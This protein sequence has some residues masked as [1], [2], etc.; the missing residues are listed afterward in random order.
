MTLAVLVLAA[1]ATSPIF[2]A[3]LRSSLNKINGNS[4]QQQ[5]RDFTLLSRDIQER[6]PI[7]NFWELVTKNLRGPTRLPPVLQKAEGNPAQPKREVDDLV[8]RSLIGSLVVL[9]AGHALEKLF[10][11]EDNN[12]RDVIPDQLAA[13]LLLATRSIEEL[14]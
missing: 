8:E 4:G 12:P 10:G 13:A 5:S 9:A 7:E 1:S 11:G 14:D 3:P 6:N 2:A